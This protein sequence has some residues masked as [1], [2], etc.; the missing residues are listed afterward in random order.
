MALVVDTG[1]LY[2]AA[3]RTDDFHGACSRLLTETDETL[4]VPA[5]VLVE[6]WWLTHRRLPPDVFDRFLATVVD[7]SLT[8]IDLTEADYRRIRELL[9]RYED[10]PLDFV[11]AAVV[12]VAERLDEPKVATLDRR[13]FSVVRPRHV[14]SFTLLP[15]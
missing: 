6:L 7:G 15:G 3:D 12:A 4:A 14:V 10:L 1:P 13:D 11:D 8:V 2:A 9:R 5:P